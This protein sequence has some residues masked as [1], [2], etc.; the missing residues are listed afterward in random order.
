MKIAL[1]DWKLLSA[2]SG[3][4]SYLSTL[5]AQRLSTVMPTE[6]FCTNGTS[7]HSTNPNG[8]SSAISCHQNKA[9]ISSRLAFK[10]NPKTERA[11]LVTS[12]RI[13]QSSA[14]ISEQRIYGTLLHFYSG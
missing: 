5:R 10:S 11:P 4:S 2:E 8:Q 12:R 9:E 14:L 13:T 1:Q 7:L 3:L 6:V